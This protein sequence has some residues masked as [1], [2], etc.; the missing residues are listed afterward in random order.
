MLLS[1]GAFEPSLAART[2]FRVAVLLEVLLPDSVLPVGP[3]RHALAQVRDPA[4]HDV[5]L[6]FLAVLAGIPR[7]APLLV[8]LVNSPDATWILR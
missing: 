6:R 1:R 3:H 7:D 2:L 8:N 5:A 4:L